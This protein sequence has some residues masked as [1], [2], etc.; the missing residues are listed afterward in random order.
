MALS[1]EQLRIAADA[2]VAARE[3]PGDGESNP[4]G[5]LTSIF[6]G[7][8]GA[9]TGSSPNKDAIAQSYGLLVANSSAG[10]VEFR[11]FFEAA[12]A[13]ADDDHWGQY[14]LDRRYAALPARE[15]GPSVPDQIADALGV[16]PVSSWGNSLASLGG[17]AKWMLWGFV[18]LLALLIIRKV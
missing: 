17:W 3:T 12:R 18:A 10:P 4:L 9:A 14:E 8:V 1:N 11:A 6:T 13:V 5:F 2:L 7:G 16:P 15:Q